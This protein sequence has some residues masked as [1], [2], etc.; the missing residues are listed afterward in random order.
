MRKAQENSANQ[1]KELEKVVQAYNLFLEGTAGSEDSLNFAQY[2]P[3]I[4]E[5]ERE[6]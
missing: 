4:E 3:S 6:I 2:R 5:S 1:A